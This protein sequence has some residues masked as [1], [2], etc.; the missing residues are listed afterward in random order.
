MLGSGAMTRFTGHTELGDGR[1]EMRIAPCVHAPRVGGHVVAE[2]TV[3]V[4]AGH[5]SQVI[6]LSR[7]PPLVHRIGREE[8]TV[9]V[10][11]AA[12]LDVP[13]PGQPE[14]LIPVAREVLLV[15]V[16]AHRAV[17]SHPFGLPIR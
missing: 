10:E 8:R 5:V 17:H 15:A 3:V 7:V 9:H 6:L 11:P 12:V 14:P 1:L 16:G 13:R 2:D 4:P